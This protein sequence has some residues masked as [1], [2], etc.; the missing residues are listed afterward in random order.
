MKVKV[1]SVEKV[2]N[3]YDIKKSVE[4]KVNECWNMNVRPKKE[5]ESETC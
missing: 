2:N 3:E 4:I 5:S 1:E